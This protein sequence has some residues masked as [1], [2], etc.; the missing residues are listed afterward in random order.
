MKTE[1]GFSF[2]S[3]V[4]LAIDGNIWL[5]LDNGRIYK[6][7]RGIQD[8]YDQQLPSGVGRAEFL[9]L[10]QESEEVVFWDEEK[11]IVWLFNKE[12]EFIS[13]TPINLDQVKDLA[14]SSDG[15]DVYLFTSDK[16]YLLKI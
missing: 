5:L 4:D 10:A 16:V 2:N 9:A 6:F 15:K 11:K 8:K 13:R 14:I 3:V 1:I 7:L 12:G